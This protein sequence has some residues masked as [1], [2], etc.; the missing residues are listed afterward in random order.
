[1]AAQEIKWNF[2]SLEEETDDSAGA[3]HDM[4]PLRAAQDAQSHEGTQR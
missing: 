3:V 1:M 2:A 4:H